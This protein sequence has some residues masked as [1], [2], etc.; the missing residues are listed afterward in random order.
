MTWSRHGPLVVLLDL[1]ILTFKGSVSKK[2]SIWERNLPFVI[3][4]RVLA[5][6]TLEYAICYSED[7][8]RPDALND[9]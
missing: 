8:V 1:L 7:Q 4:P 6:L 3:T 5:T 9:L 2:S